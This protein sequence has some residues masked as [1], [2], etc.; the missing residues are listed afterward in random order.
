MLGISGIIKSTACLVCKTGLFDTL[1]KSRYPVNDSSNPN[2]FLVPVEKS[3]EL[4]LNFK[5]DSLVEKVYFNVVISG[6]TVTVIP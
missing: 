2:N 6:I 1:S 3:V 5:L 4:K